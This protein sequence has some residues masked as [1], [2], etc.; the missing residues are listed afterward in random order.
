MLG[1]GCPTM[2]ISS[3][4]YDGIKSILHST[5]GDII[6][7]RVYKGSRF[8]NLVRLAK[9]YGRI[10][11]GMDTF[12]GLEE[13]SAFDKSNGRFS[14]YPKGYANARP[15]STHSAIRKVCGS[16][17]PYQLYEGDVLTIINQLPDRKYAVA[18]IDL[19]HYNPTKIAL[20]YMKYH[21][22]DGGVI[23]V[24]NYSPE[25]N[26]LSSRAITEF[27]KDNNLH[28]S[29]IDASTHKL[30]TSPTSA[31]N[32]YIPIPTT[33]PNKPKTT[34]VQDYEPIQM[35]FKFPKFLNEN[36]TDIVLVLKT[37]GDTYNCKY[38]NAA[39]RNIKNNVTSNYKLSVLTDDSSGID[40][41][42]V[43]NI[44]PLTHNFGGWWSKI[45]LF[46]PNLFKDRVFYMD[47]DTVIVRN[48]DHM[49]EFCP[50]FGGIRDLYH[51]DFLQTGLMVWD[52][53][54]NTHIY[55]NFV[56][57]SSE[58]MEK[59]RNSG[60]AGW[61]RDSIINFEYI[62]DAFPREVVSWKAHCVNRND[63]KF[64]RIP[65]DASIICFH[66]KPRPHTIDHP[67]I[68]AHWDYH[69]G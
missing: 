13:P 53:T 40:M 55:T 38:V 27:V 8:S 35:Q 57:N 39:A 1:R 62:S 43:D 67:E 46:R 15:E 60:D 18:I 49:L 26:L 21:L 50:D 41:E 24:S 69:S 56:N 12:Y 32:P 51:Y 29:H 17:A 28:C 10:A 19:I 16:D 31:T 37:G 59:Y 6:D 58:I 9:E 47:L 2:V 22:S 30:S 11:I 4:V 68:V 7:F 3:T 23:L 65:R 34:A 63:D 48:I 44:I 66:G 64:V 33:L 36:P 54:K 61:I 5:E 42:L 52:A 14:Q 25:S 45:E 20:D